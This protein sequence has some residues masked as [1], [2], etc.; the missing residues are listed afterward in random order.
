MANRSELAADP[1][2]A[3]RVAEGYRQA[4]LTAG[5]KDVPASREV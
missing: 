3:M 4:A 5:R 2:T 1:N